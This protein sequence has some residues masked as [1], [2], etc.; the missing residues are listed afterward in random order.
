MR[1]PASLRNVGLRT[2]AGV[3]FEPTEPLSRLTV[4]HC[5]TSITGAMTSSSPRLSR[6]ADWSALHGMHAPLA[7]CGTA[8]TKALSARAGLVADAA[9]VPVA[10]CEPTVGADDEPFARPAL[11][12]GS[13]T[14]HEPQ[15]EPL[16]ECRAW[17]N[18]R[19]A[20]QGSVAACFPRL[21]GGVGFE[22]TGPLSGLNAF[23]RCKALSPQGLPVLRR[24]AFPA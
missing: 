16:Q 1:L 10:A 15:G 8:Q 6:C 5:Q 7:A 20:H 17:P 18:V 4:S 14:A 21:G 19:V 23:K 11:N 12:V 3:G 13:P 22:P 2:A 24:W 9:D